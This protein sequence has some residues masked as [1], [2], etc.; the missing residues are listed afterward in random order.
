MKQKYYTEGETQEQLCINFLHQVDSILNDV[1]PMNTVYCDDSAVYASRIHELRKLARQ[2]TT[3]LKV[4]H[5]DRLELE[6]A[7][8]KND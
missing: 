3:D 1:M 7:Y 2:V 6:K 5:Y 4:L 8:S